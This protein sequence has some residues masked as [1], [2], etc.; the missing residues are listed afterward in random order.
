MDANTIIRRACAVIF[1]AA[2]VLLV[3]TIG[4]VGWGLWSIATS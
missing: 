1:V 2:A 3:I 4:V